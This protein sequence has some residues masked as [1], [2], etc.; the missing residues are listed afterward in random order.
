MHPAP[1]HSPPRRRA[2]AVWSAALA[3]AAP[4]GA[5]GCRAEPPPAAARSALIVTL[6]TTRA[7]A[8]SCTGAPA[9]LTP[10]LD[11]LASEG[12]LFTQART[13][14]PITLPAHASLFTGLTP[15][16]H[17]V[18][19]NSLQPL[20]PQALTLAERARAAG[21]DTAAF[22]AA[23][24]LDSA[25]GLDQ[26]FDRYV[27][28]PRGA[29]TRQSVHFV[30]RSA[31]AV[32]DD[33]LAWLGARERARP[34]L[35]WVHFFDPHAPYQP[36]EEFR[37]RAG[38]DAYLGEVARVDFALGRILDE[39][40]RQGLM[41]ETLV[42]VAGDHGEGRGE[43]GEATHGALTFDSTLRVPLIVRA[44][45]SAAAGQRSARAVG[46]VDVAP[47]VAAAM[48][49][50]ALPGIDGR[51]LLSS[52]ATP[53]AGV[54]FES[55]YGFLH[56][57]WS[58]I[59]GWCDGQR[60]Y[61]F[62]GQDACFDLRLDPGETR[63]L[64]REQPDCAESFR[65]A[66][67]ALAARPR[68]AGTGDIDGELRGAIQ[69]L[70]YAAEAPAP[71]RYP[72]PL[73]STGRPPARERQG[74]VERMEQAIAH[75]QAKRFGAA[76]EILR[77][78]VQ[79]NPYNESAGSRLAAFLI[80]DGKTGEALPILLKLEQSGAPRA[81]DALNLGYCLQAAGRDA[82]AVPRFER[83]LEL[84]PGSA[85]AR[86]NLVVVLKR[87]GRTREAAE[88]EARPGR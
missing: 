74:E 85:Q 41:R 32:A 60:K 27:D 11:R 40:E 30:E 13:S 5:W 42:V 37:R 59:T 33:V 84:D 23:A 26:G 1:A 63:N 65:K 15:L 10:R 25:F 6:D 73:E 78:V 69:Q 68:L 8:L 2:L 28:P 86:S 80:A 38:G 70:G 22:V 14:A 45:G 47:T 19:D 79:E 64:A 77:Q 29:G 83:A 3:L 35:L 51:D 58:P 82:E 71:S 62:D 48:G 21:L 52:T 54:Y 31:E 87:L 20:P 76:A 43:H 9:G 4:A 49:L 88:V 44:P 66:V 16:R 7:D 72:E 12:L 39:L 36:P 67:G 55:Y 17:G 34:F 24:V 57:G 61:S 81:D 53:E 56:Y 18:R 46:L 75:S 50:A